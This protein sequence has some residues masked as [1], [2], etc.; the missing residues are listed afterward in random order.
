M[1]AR[2]W[3]RSGE[4][5][6]VVWCRFD[7]CFKTYYLVEAAIPPECPGCRRQSRDNGVWWTVERPE[8]KPVKGTISLNDIR[9]LKSIRIAPWEGGIDT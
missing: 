4:T 6:L 9:F 8:G 3:Y 2:A 5:P 7:D 1:P